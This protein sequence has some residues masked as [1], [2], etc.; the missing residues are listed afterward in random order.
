MGVWRLRRNRGAG[1]GD[2]PASDGMLALRLSTTTGT[3]RT[4]YVRHGRR[5]CS[6]GEYRRLDPGDHGDETVAWRELGNSTRSRRWL[7]AAISCNAN[8]RRATSRL[9]DLCEATV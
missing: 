3:G 5:A 1:D 9:S 7:V 6:G 8:A 2:R 4:A